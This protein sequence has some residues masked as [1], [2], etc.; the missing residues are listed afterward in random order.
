M[1]GN[2]Y[3]PPQGNID[4]FIEILE[5]N[6]ENIDLDRIELFL[7]GDFNIDWSDKNN[8]NCK[9][10]LEL[11]KSLGLRQLIRDV[12]RP[13][14]NRNSCIDLIITNSHNIERAGVINISLSDHL[15]VHCNKKKLKVPK[16][17]CDFI[18]R[19][20][21][22]YDKETLQQNIRDANWEN[23]DN[24]LDVT[25]KWELFENIIREHIDNMCPLKHC[26]VKQQK[27]PWITN[28]LLELIKDKDAILKC[29]RKRKDI[30]LWAEARRLRNQCVNRLRD[31]RA[32]FIKKKIG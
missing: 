8:P 17:K 24:I 19:S 15:L 4:S 16:E 28:E 13:T 32:E 11:T 10:L 25:E 2:I 12:T 9:K 18:G 29:A 6:I 23:Y 14:Q 31:V 27:E 30:Q 21:R 22:H 7:M 20:Y 3:R 1:I 5:E 26:K